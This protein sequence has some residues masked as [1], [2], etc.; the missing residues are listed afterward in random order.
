M[1]DYSDSFTDFDGNIWLNCAHQGPMPKVTIEELNEALEWKLSPYHLTS[2]RFREVP[3][4]MKSAIGELINI[5]PEEVILTNGASYGIH[6]LANGIPWKSGD[7]VLL[8]QGDFPSD[9]LPW[10]ALKK[11]GVT[12]RL[13]E[14]KEHVLSAEELIENISPSSKLLCITWVHSLSGYAIDIAKLGEICKEKG[15]IFVVNASQAL[16]V[17]ALNISNIHIDA[18]VS[19]GFKWL[20]GPY[21]TGFCWIRSEILESLD[22]NQAYW[23]AMMT[24][25]DLGKKQDILQFP[26]NLGAKKYDIFCTANF[27]NFK[28]WEASVKFLLEIGIEKIELHNNLLISQFIEGLDNS[29]YDLI[30]P[31]EGGK[32]SSLIFI[33]HRQPE[34]N[35][36]VYD[37]LKKNNIHISFR[38]G[39][40]RISPHVYNTVKDIEATLDLL[41]S[42]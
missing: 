7:E 25:D 31:K 9:I 10:L 6:L 30:S 20:C 5:P 19:V 37:I 2:A 28:P 29:K 42:I 34:M 40:L 39:R 11:K 8:M 3:S 16:G 12:I 17:R 32:R 22:Y 41:N 36:K 26:Q 38:G 23:L 27:F 1:T 24:A 13:I 21:G 33:S 4:K 35:E 15:I 14:P 18:L